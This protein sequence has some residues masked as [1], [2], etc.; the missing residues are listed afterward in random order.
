MWGPASLSSTHFLVF[1]WC[2]CAF[3]SLDAQHRGLCDANTQGLEWTQRVELLRQVYS[4]A[5]AA[6]D[7]M[8]YHHYHV[9][10]HHV[11]APMVLRKC[12]NGEPF[13]MLE[14]G[15]G[16]GTYG[17]GSSQSAGGSVAGWHKLLAALPTAEYHNMEYDSKCMEDWVRRHPELGTQWATMHTGNQGSEYDLDRVFGSAPQFDVIIDDGSHLNEHQR[18]TLNYSL[19]TL[20]V[21][22]GGVYIIED[23]QSACKT[24]TINEPRGDG[25][26]AQKARRTGGSPGDCLGSKT[27]PTIF[28]SIVEYQRD[29]LHRKLQL[30]G[31]RHIDIFEEAAVFWVNRL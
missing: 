10:Y 12:M 15:L 23:I 28:R 13:R 31:V 17:K 8:G 24:F 21:A 29:L 19:Q 16:C 18:F 26:E 9:M 3:G 30:P 2:C 4:N 6:S 5:S 7:K 22:N 11:L 14:I 27:Q 20:R 25:L 1:C